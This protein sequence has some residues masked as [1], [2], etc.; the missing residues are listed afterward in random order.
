MQLVQLAVVE[1]TRSQ[2]TKTDESGN[3][4]SMLEQIEKED[5][6]EPRKGGEVRNDNQAH[7]GDYSICEQIDQCL[8]FFIG[9]PDPVERSL[10]KLLTTLY[11][12][13]HTTDQYESNES[14]GLRNKFQ[15]IHGVT[16]I[17]DVVRGS[18][19]PKSDAES[20]S[21]A[22]DEPD[23]LRLTFDQCSTSEEAWRVSANHALASVHIQCL[24]EETPATI[25]EL[26]AEFER[27][28]AQIFAGELS[29]EHAERIRQRLV[30]EYGYR[31]A[32]CLLARSNM[33]ELSYASKTP[34]DERRAKQRYAKA[35]RGSGLIEDK[36]IY[37]KEVF[38]ALAISCAQ[39]RR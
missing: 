19:H 28:T 17:Y 21:Y 15:D 34:R 26:Q 10:Q 22:I 36:V 37:W 6:T 31:F 35:W 8:A 25:D 33:K 14:T 38:I 18:E 4:D 32:H 3:E 2:D 11:D 16:T 23:S 13:T 5:I 9:V 30:R 24:L 20:S 12:D 39:L 27:V 7:K 29:T 1:A